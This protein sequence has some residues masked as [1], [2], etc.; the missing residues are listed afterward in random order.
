[1]PTIAHLIENGTM[2]NISTL[3]P[4]FSP[5]LWTTIATGMY[6]FKHGV[7]GFTEPRQNMQGVQPITSLSRKVKAKLRIRKPK[8]L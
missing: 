8:E 1:M 5:M 6:P 4:P 3:D 7:L 2:G